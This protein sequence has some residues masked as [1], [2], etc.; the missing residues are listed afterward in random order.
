[1]IY[2]YAKL[3][4]KAWV[5]SFC[6]SST[7]ALCNSRLQL[8]MCI[9]KSFFEIK[10]RASFSQSEQNEMNWTVLIKQLQFMRQFRGNVLQF[11]ANFRPK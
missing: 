2:A 7:W 3:L 6:M 5:A 11:R 4:K 10:K 1:M 9:L 8:Q